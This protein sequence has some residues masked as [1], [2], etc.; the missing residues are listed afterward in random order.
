MDSTKF[1]DLGTWAGAVF[2]YDPET[3]QAWTAVMIEKK[4]VLDDVISNAVTR[5]MNAGEFGKHED[6]LY[7]PFCE[8][9]NRVLQRAREIIPDL[10]AYPVPDLVLCRNAP[11]Y[12]GACSQ[13]DASRSPDIVL[14]SETT[15]RD[16]KNRNK[17]TKTKGQ[18][19]PTTGIDWSDL[20][21]IWEMKSF[22]AWNLKDYM[23]R[24]RLDWDTKL[25]KRRPEVEASTSSGLYRGP[26]PA[27]LNRVV[28]P[29]SEPGPEDNPLKRYYPDFNSADNSRPPKRLRMQPPESIPLALETEGEFLASKK[30]PV[31]EA[32]EDQ[33]ATYALE[34]LSC[35]RG[36]RLY[37]FQC[38]VMGD[39]VE[40]WYSDAS[41]IVRS[42]QIS[43]IREFEKFAAFLVAMACCDH[44][45]FGMVVPNLSPPAED[46]NPSLPPASLNGYSTTM[47]HPTIGIDVKVTLGRE[48]FT[49]YSLIGRKT[50][51]YD[52]TTEP[53]I[54]DEPLV[55][56]MSLQSVC[57]TPEQDLLALAEGF[58]VS[59]HLPKVYMWTARATEWRLSDGVRGRFFK[60]NDEDK[61]YEER[62]QR[63]IL[64]KKYKQLETVL[65]PQNMDHV[66]NQLLDCLHDLY[67]QL[68]MLHRDVSLSNLMYEMR[69]GLVWLILNDFDL[70]VVIKK[71]G[72][73]RGSTGRHRTGTL[74][75]MA[76]DLIE[77]PNMPH[78]FRHDLESVFFVA[79]WCAIR[80]PSRDQKTDALRRK[81]LLSWEQYGLDTI[82]NSKTQIFVSQNSFAKLVPGKIPLSPEF[83][84][85][86]RWL[87]AFWTV[88]FEGYQDLAAHQKKISDIRQNEREGDISQEEAEQEIKAI[89]FD[90]E[91]FDGKITYSRIKAASK[92]CKGRLAKH[93]RGF[94]F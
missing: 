68:H 16:L 6:E 18:K 38:L 85:Y 51:V 79:L 11:V 78:Y 66:F 33:M 75:F 25:T 35:T 5:F 3:I 27:Q 19:Y 63:F 61:E 50:C 32:Y 29:L 54:S 87:G 71:D 69:E 24:L 92:V 83:S 48:V 80:S 84:R 42:H 91:T 64:F 67:H 55:M 73:P 57:R 49:Q 58:P 34:M 72:P 31:P 45:R 44:S 2:G 7:A 37:F 52:V 56:K 36:T 86:E 53:P 60:R 30:L 93:L 89:V 28:G 13:G 20:F 65:S 62:C 81:A 43:W 76:V 8:V 4:I 47:K 88:L 59:E 1:L 23:A 14:V 90:A 17:Y 94:V 10:P 22:N 40:F 46:F 9:A 41:G 12:I 70:A 15:M 74:P 82:R 39:I 77:D 26:D 21:S